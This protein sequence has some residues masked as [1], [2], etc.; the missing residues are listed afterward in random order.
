MPRFLK[1]AG[2]VAL[3]SIAAACDDINTDSERAL[4]GAGIGCA[5]GE[6]FANGECVAGA[7]AGAAAGALANDVFG[8]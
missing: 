6:V 8:R 7:L 4:V 2:A 3:L 5:A 1:F